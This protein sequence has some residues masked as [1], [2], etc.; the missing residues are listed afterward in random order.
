MKGM[1]LFMKKDKKLLVRLIID[2]LKGKN[3]LTYEEISQLTGYHCKYILRLKKEM[4]ETGKVNLKYKRESSWNA[5][6]KEEE[7]KIVNLYKKSHVSVRK[8]SKFYGSRSYS[9]I[10]NVLKRNGL[11]D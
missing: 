6:S 2:K 8:F 1:K 4:I 7:E 10:Y 11:L 5:L 9:C 3:S